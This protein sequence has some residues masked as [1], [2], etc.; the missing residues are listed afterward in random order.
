MIFQFSFRRYMAEILTIRLKTQYNNSTNQFS[1]M[2][3]CCSHC[4]II[5]SLIMCE[6]RCLLRRERERE[7]EREGE[8]E[9]KQ[10][11]I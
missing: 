2:I 9:R 3:A 10:T 6:S 1:L 11:V 7:G 8:R 4:S 5:L